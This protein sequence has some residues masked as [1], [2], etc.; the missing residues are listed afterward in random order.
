MSRFSEGANKNQ[1]KLEAQHFFILPK[2]S[3]Y[4]KIFQCERHS[5]TQTSTIR[6]FVLQLYLKKTFLKKYR[7][8]NLER[9]VHSSFICRIAVPKVSLKPPCKHPQQD[10]FFVKLQAISFTKNGLHN[11]YFFL[12]VFQNYSEKLFFITPPVCYLFLDDSLN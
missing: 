7:P 6:Y 12:E 1:T 4:Y 8:Q 3:L 9:A 10:K 2:Q 11:G 5:P